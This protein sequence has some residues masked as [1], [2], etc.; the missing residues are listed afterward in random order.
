MSIVYTV[1]VFEPEIT[2]NYRDTNILWRAH[3]NTNENYKSIVHSILKDNIEIS[4]R[5]K[6]DNWLRVLDDSDIKYFNKIDTDY[7]K[8]FT[9]YDNNGVNFI[10][11]FFA[12]DIKASNY[13]VEIDSQNILPILFLLDLGKSGNI[14]PRS[15]QKRID[16]AKQMIIHNEDQNVNTANDVLTYFKQIEKLI[17]HC[18]NYEHNIKYYIKER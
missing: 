14:F 17:M 2:I 4:N 15:L 16:Q 12:C 7:F 18:E 10:I 6:L 5:R 8:E 13:Y 1:L 11:S 9:I 3:L